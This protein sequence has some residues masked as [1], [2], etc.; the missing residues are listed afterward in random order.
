VGTSSNRFG[1]GARI[2]V[3][4]TAGAPELVREVRGGSNFLGQNEMIAHFG[5]G[6][7]TG[8][9]SEVRVRWP[10]AGN[11]QVLKD[12]PINQV[13]VVTEP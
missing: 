4:P 3:L 10:R 5:L 13:L 1:I 9:V 8:T 12:V 7:L 6:T 11:E 2:T